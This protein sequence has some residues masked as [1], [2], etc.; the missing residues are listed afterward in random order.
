VTELVL[1]FSSLAYLTDAQLSRLTRIPRAET[2]LK[3]AL[4]RPHLDDRLSVLERLIALYDAWNCPEEIP[5]LEQELT[6]LRGPLGGRAP[7]D[8]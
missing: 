3:Q 8:A 6:A 1:E 5:P 2:L 4:G 7:R